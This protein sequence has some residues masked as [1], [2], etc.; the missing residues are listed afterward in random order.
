MALSQYDL[1]KA[2]R[3]TAMD[4]EGFQCLLRP[5]HDVAHRW[6]RCET[7]D[8]RGHRCALPLQHTGGHEPPWYDRPTDQ[9]QTRTLHY[10]GSL[11]ETEAVSDTTTRIANRYGWARQSQA[12]RPGFFWRSRPLSRWLSAI[13]EPQGRLTVVFEY[14]PPAA[15]AETKS[16]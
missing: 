7:S 9:G 8:F 12:F 15:T 2:L 10:G 13:E 3:C 11:P 4:D 5:S 16:E 14:K 1:A 6:N